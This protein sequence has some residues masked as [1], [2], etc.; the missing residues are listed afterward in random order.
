VKYVKRNALAGRD[1]QNF[2][3]LE[4]H[5]VAWMAEADR[6]IHG[7]THEEP[8]LRFDRD[9]KAALRPLPG[10]PLRKRIQRLRRRV[11]HDA[12]VDVDTVRYSVPHLLVREHV[13]VELGDEAV[14][15]FRGA[16]LVA[17]HVRSREPHARV[18]DPAHWAGLWKPHAAE[19]ATDSPL[20]ALGRSL[21]DYEALLTRGAA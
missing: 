8:I 19:P 10:R 14:R 6:R 21:A 5:L 15:I 11:A 9:E 7:T 17:T 16:E 12:L 18:V 4:R 2:A 20:E 3:H 1:F 13:D